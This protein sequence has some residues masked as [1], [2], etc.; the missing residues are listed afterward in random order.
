MQSM[1]PSTLSPPQFVDAT[2]VS[3]GLIESLGP[4]MSLQWI[5]HTPVEDGRLVVGGF[6]DTTQVPGLVTATFDSGVLQEFSYSPGKSFGLFPVIGLRMYSVDAEDPAHDPRTL[7][8]KLRVFDTT[9]VQDLSSI[10]FSNAGVC[11]ID[12][13]GK[14]YSGSELEVPEDISQKAGVDAMKRIRSGLHGRVTKWCDEQRNA[15]IF[16][17]G[18]KRYMT[19]M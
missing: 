18:D 19:I 4:D 6:P 14:Q 3:S 10:V 7:S 15:A 11:V 16:Q 5:Q 17:L 2:R 8:N 12:A 13:S 1:K 9:A